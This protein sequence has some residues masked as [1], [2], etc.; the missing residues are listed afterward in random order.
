[1]SAAWFFAGLGGASFFF[2]GRFLP[3]GGGDTVDW[4]VAWVT[5]SPVTDLGFTAEAT[6]QF[7]AGIVLLLSFPFVLHALAR[8][9]IATDKAELSLG[10]SGVR[11]PATARTGEVSAA[12]VEG[13]F[14]DAA[15]PGLEHDSRVS[16]FLTRGDGEG[17]FWLLSIFVGTVLL[18]I[19]WPVTA[20]LYGVWTVTAMQVAIG[21]SAS[22]VLAVRMPAATLVLGV[23]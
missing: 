3:E 14:T 10:R 6:F 13:G 21:Q 20:G 5:D 16:A 12:P 18:A 1:V 19:S 22:L 7:A 15:A 23:M 17:W 2:W 8:L 9:E 11:S 4:V